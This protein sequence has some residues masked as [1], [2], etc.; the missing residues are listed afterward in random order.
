MIARN[1]N[2][3]ALIAESSHAELIKRRTGD[4]PKGVLTLN[5]AKLSNN[6][7]SISSRHYGIVFFTD[8]YTFGIR[9]LSAL[10]RHST[11]LPYKAG[12][13]HKVVKGVVQVTAASI[14]Q[15]HEEYLNAYFNTCR[16]IENIDD[17][18]AVL[19]AES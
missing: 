9:S 10:V 14:L 1:L 15:T 18:I 13:V 8:D 5:E 7:Q 17:L 11:K 16:L 3:E 4:Y 19:S 6:I 2:K 12:L